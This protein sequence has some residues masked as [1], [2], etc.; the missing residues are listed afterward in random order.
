MRAVVTGEDEPTGGYEG[1]AASIDKGNE[2]PDARELGL[3][4]AAVIAGTCGRT[5]TRR[6]LYARHPRAADGL[7]K[8]GKSVVLCG[9]YELGEPICS[10]LEHT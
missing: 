2:V 4:L 3:E 1:H 10:G 7:S 9:R 8:S 5:P 6:A